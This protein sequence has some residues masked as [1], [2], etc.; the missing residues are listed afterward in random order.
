MDVLR[1]LQQLRLDGQGF[2]VRKALTATARQFPLDSSK[3]LGAI[4]LDLSLARRFFL[5]RPFR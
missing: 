3:A 5:S 1:S 2:M 4:A